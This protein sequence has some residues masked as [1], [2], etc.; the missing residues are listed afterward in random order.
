MALFCA[1]LY[2]L[3]N[4]YQPLT[5]MIYLTAVHV[6][7][8]CIS[9]GFSVQDS[10]NL[11]AALNDGAE[12]FPGRS[13]ESS[14]SFHLDVEAVLTYHKAPVCYH[15]LKNLIINCCSFLLTLLPYY[16]TLFCRFCRRHCCGTLDSKNPEG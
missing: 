5:C 6:D 14:S 8:Q 11:R 12:A 7:D 16:T 13:T 2:S 4:K 9:C 3:Y 1:T 15:C 10:S